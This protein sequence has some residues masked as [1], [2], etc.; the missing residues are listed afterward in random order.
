[1]ANR[2]QSLLSAYTN[3]VSKPLF[4]ELSQLLKEGGD[5]YPNKIIIYA[6]T[7]EAI[8]R[9][10]DTKLI[11]FLDSDPHLRSVEYIDINGEMPKKEKTLKIFHFVNGNDPECDFKILLATSGVGNAGIDSKEI[12]AVFRLDMP[13][14]VYDLSQEMGRAGRTNIATQDDYFYQ[15]FFTLDH[16]RYLFR[17]IHETEESGCVDELYKSVQ[18]KDLVTVVEILCNT[19]ACHK[20]LLETVLGNPRGN[21]TSFQNCSKC[22]NCTDSSSFPTLCKEGTRFVLFDVF[23]TG[24]DGPPS[25]DNVSKKLQTYPEVQKHLFSKSS[26]RNA[27]PI[28][29]DKVLFTMI[30]L[31]ILSMKYNVTVDGNITFHL[32]KIGPNSTTL[33]LMDDRYWRS[34]NCKAAII[35]YND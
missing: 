20:R 35:V 18:V 3:R 23:T 12:R 14:S 19:K 31:R 25:Y 27:V 15:V 7:R 1:M 16:V 13:A 26:N 6:N 30:G 29:V 28:D 24:F 5:N 22:A 33:C 34:V 8:L 4:T 2:K 9:F 10:L 17:R 21:R 11:E 32:N